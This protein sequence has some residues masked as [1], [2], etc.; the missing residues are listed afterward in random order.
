MKP[1]VKGYCLYWRAQPPA[2]RD[3][4]LR[5][6]DLV[7]VG[8][9]GDVLRRAERIED[10]EHMVLL[11]E[12]ARLLDGLGRVVRVVEVLVVDLAPVHLAGVLEVRG[13]ALGRQSAGGCFAAQRNRD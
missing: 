13:R 5:D 2:A 6:A 9:R 3:E 12:L 11:D 4:E 10:R 7:E 8:A 1:I